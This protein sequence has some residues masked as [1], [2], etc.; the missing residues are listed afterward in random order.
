MLMRAI[1]A[2]FLF[3]I[4]IVS[5]PTTANA[6]S[7]LFKPAYYKEQRD[8]CISFT[9]AS[10]E[11]NGDAGYTELDAFDVLDVRDWKDSDGI[12][13]RI[14]VY[15]EG[16]WGV[17]TEPERERK[18]NRILTQQ[19]S[20][21]RKPTFDAK[22]RSERVGISMDNFRSVVRRVASKHLS[23]TVIGECTYFSERSSSSS[24][25]LIRALR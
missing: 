3:V 20:I 17:Y 16:K 24:H 6:F 4:A 12:H 22:M 23:Q 21:F 1:F 10:V 11:Y 14:R 18:T 13:Y 15:T 7:D 5:P 2:I 8:A 25:E 9:R 19:E